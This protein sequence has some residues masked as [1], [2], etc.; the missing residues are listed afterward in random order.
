MSSLL[1]NLSSH[2]MAP[3]NCI[4]ELYHPMVIE[5]FDYIDY[6]F[7]LISKYSF[8]FDII[9]IIML[10]SLICYQI[11]YLDYERVNEIENLQ[12]K[13]KLLEN[14]LKL[15]SEVSINMIINQLKKDSNHS[16]E[17]L[18]P[19]SCEACMNFFNDIKK[20]IN[21]PLNQ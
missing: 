1:F 8:L 9:I 17:Q 11:F 21:T 6:I 16:Y 12:R 20:R 18:I 5:E 3:K 14:A 15:S 7:F 2:A 10:S 4:L 13:N 19:C